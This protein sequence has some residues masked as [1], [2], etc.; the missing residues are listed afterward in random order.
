MGRNGRML[1][2]P[3]TDHDAARRLGRIIADGHGCV[4]WIVNHRKDGSAFWNLLFLSPVH[5]A[6]GTLLHFFGNQ[7]DIS[8]GL[9][10]R[11]SEVGLGPAHMP[12]EA[13]AE[14]DRL[15]RES[16]ATT[17]TADPAADARALEQVLASARQ[18]AEVSTRL[19]PGPPETN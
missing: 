5:D 19:V 9:P 12:P 4:E 16:A 13:A 8:E 14:F 7:H 1:Q 2:G 11:L 3:R 6:D 15:L 18:L 10:P 17:R